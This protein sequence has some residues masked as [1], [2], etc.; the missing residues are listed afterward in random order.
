MSEQVTQVEVPVENTQSDKKKRKMPFGHYKVSVPVFDGPDKKYSVFDCKP[1]SQEDLADGWCAVLPKPKKFRKSEE[2]DS[3]SQPIHHWSVTL[4]QLPAHLWRD[5]FYKVD[6]DGKEYL[7]V[8]K[9]NIYH[10]SINKTEYD[11]TIVKLFHEL[12]KGYHADKSAIKT[13]VDSLEGKVNGWLMI[14]AKKFLK[15]TVSSPVLLY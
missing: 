1:L 11:D 5:N 3:K 6:E 12:Q 14:R 2:S 8:I 9:D 7:A 4:A 13:M 10:Y 15:G